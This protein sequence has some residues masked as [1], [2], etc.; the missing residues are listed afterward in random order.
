M[1]SRTFLNI[2]WKIILYYYNLKELVLY[3]K[4]KKKTLFDISSSIYCVSII[5]WKNVLVCYRVHKLNVVLGMQ[6]QDNTYYL[7]NILL[8][9][10]PNG[11]LNI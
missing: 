11:T 2:H 4:I 7:H 3:C 10:L 5:N 8:Q 6:Q 9:L 1:C